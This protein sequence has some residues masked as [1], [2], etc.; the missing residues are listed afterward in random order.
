MRAAD[1]VKENRD[2]TA[3]LPKTTRACGVVIL[4]L[5]VP[6]VLTTRRALDRMIEIGR[7]ERCHEH[8]D[9]GK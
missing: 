1:V 9:Q 8:T 5:G 2:C 6:V 7:L 4:A 3:F